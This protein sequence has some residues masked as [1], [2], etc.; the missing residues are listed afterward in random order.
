MAATPDAAS[1]DAASPDPAARA[2]G[3]EDGPGGGTAPGPGAG[4][5]P[6]DRPADPPGLPGAPEQA[7]RFQQARA[8][9][10]TQ[11]AE[12]YVELI[13]DLIAT[14]GEARPVE[15]ARRLGVS[16]ATVAKAVARLKREGLV[17]GQPYRGLF[18][19]PEGEA[20]AAQARERHR[21]VV[22]FLCALGVGAR[23][24]E[25]DAEGIEH[26]V[27]PETLAAFRRFLGQAGG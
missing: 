14:A 1:P 2:A 12:D 3:P 21:L 13:S 4:G 23:A 11:A 26:H 6:G 7:E 16:H 10:Q 27:G 8:A 18:L 19:T 9:R 5:P 24:A 25:I 17:R 22:D 20:R 15:I